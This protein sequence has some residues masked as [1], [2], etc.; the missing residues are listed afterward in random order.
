MHG[1]VP[2]TRDDDGAL[3]ITVEGGVEH[4]PLRERVLLL[5]LDAQHAA[6]T[7]AGTVANDDEPAEAPAP[8]P[9]KAKK[10]KRAKAAK[11]EQ[12]P[13]A[14]SSWEEKFRADALAALRDIS[15][16]SPILLMERMGR[17]RQQKL[18]DALN[19]MRDD[20]LITITG[21]TV[22]RTISLAE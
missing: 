1:G 19:R 21:N 15:P 12:A 13:A 9:R 7:D 11:K 14:V 17:S 20:G 10:A 18:R 6:N 5:V 3:T 16:C 2:C 22:N 4:G 8:A